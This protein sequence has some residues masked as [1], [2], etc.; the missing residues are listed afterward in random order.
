MPSKLQKSETEYERKTDYVLHFQASLDKR[1]AAS[2]ETRKTAPQ[3]RD[4][5]RSDG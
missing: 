5:V 1:D 4:Y 3:A 2:N